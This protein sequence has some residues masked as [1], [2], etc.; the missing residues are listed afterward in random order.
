VAASVSYFPVN[1]GGVER[2]S[3][4]GPTPA[5]QKIARQIDVLQ[6]MAKNERDQKWGA[7]HVAEM[8]DFFEL[9]YYPATA[10]PSYRPRIILP[11]LQYLLMSE[12]TDLTNDTP[13]C[14][15]S[16]NGKQ[17]EAREKAFAATWKGGLFNNRIFEAVFWSQFANPSWLQLGVNPYARNGR[18]SVWMRSRDP[19]TVFPDAHAKNDRDWSYV[20][21]EDY[22][23]IDEVKRNWPEHGKR[24][25]VG[26]G[27]DDYQ[28]PETGGSSFD[29]SMELPPGPLRVDAP[30]GFEHQ[31][32][33]PRVRVRYAWVKDYAIDVIREIAGTETAR[34]FELAIKPITKYKFPGGRFITECQNVVLADGQNWVP[35]LP[36][37]DFGTFPL[38]GVWSMPHVSSLYGPPPVRYGK[39][40]QDIAER[41]YTQLVENMIRTNNVQCWIPEDSGIDIDAY[42]GLPGE[43]QVYRG[44]KP[45]TMTTPPQLPQH[46]TQ[47]P[48]LLLQK[49]ARY[50]GW[51]PE[52]Q[53]KAGDG[54]VSTDLFDASLFQSETLLRMKARMLSETYQRACEMAF[55]MMVRFKTLEDTIRPARGNRPAAVWTP[56]PESAE[57][58]L[59]MDDTS[60]DAISSAMLRKLVVPL[61]K[62]G[63]I[64]AKYALETVG[65]PHAEELAEAAQ[66]QMALAALSK[67]KKPR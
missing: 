49:V 33:G 56:V 3:V 28:E 26:P 45:P 1:I 29:L 47:V 40:P 8:K 17:D 5:E 37:D 10:Q 21:C 51:T 19:E 22:F 60:V 42:G 12:S 65:V 48:E 66:Q 44:D 4:P 7:N 58:Y 9:N 13:K 52:R 59:E 50:V 61:A 55:R 30:Q 16:V 57:T 35:L 63:L 41:M 6:S 67:L 18:G 54:N 27:Y 11:E 14:F 53:G 62:L 25:R 20:V 23:Y 32:N 43:V 39:G 46:M 24:I 2:K 64:P 15:I 31:R 38:I 36:E 34:G